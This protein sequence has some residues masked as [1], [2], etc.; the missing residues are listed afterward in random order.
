MGDSTYKAL[1]AKIKAGWQEEKLYGIYHFQHAKPIVFVCKKI[2][3]CGNFPQRCQHPKT[4]GQ[5]LLASNKNDR[6]GVSKGK[7][8]SFWCHGGYICSEA[9]LTQFIAIL[10]RKKIPKT[11]TFFN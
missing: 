3:Q 11:A 10:N 7:T 2:K 6:I 9:W 1:Q 8:A 4:Y 5:V